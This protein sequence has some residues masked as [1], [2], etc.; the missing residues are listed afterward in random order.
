MDARL[1]WRLI[2]DICKLGEFIA[3]A[4]MGGVSANIVG[5]FKVGYDGSETVIER[6]DC[7][8]HI[9][10]YPDQITAFK[11]RYCDVGHG[12]EPCLELINQESQVCLRFYYRGDDAGR[13]YRQFVE[14]HSQHES[15]F[16]GEW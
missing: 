14:Q 2:A 9:H 13:K 3:T 12:V 4:G 10:C 7:D 11:F 1:F 16:A 5:R 6:T 15:L 8:D